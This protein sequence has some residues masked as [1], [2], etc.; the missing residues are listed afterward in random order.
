MQHVPLAY[1]VRSGFAE[2]THYGC[3][4]VLDSTRNPIVQAGDIKAPVFLR[5]AAKPLQ[6]VAMME[7][8]LSLREPHLVAL[9][10]GSH[11]GEAMHIDGVKEILTKAQLDESS[12]EN[13]V[14][15]PLSADERFKW[16]QTGRKPSHLAQNC[17]GQHAA[18][19]LCCVQVGWNIA[20]YWDY[21]HPLQKVTVEIV[22]E[23]AGEKIAAVGIDGCGLPTFGVSLH[24]LACAFSRLAMSNGPGAEYRVATAIRTC[25][26]WM[27]GPTRKVTRL[28]QG[29]KGLIAKEGA[30]GV[31]AASLPNGVSLAVKISDGNVRALWPVVAALFRE[32]EVD[33]PILEE[34]SIVPIIG[35]G[36]QVGQIQVPRLR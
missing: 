8:G 19:L 10:T 2:G 7:A 14:D 1:V 36:H 9:A 3:A 21:K 25:P 26:E 13:T 11:S 33:A 34:L 5:S 28:V 6:V 16:E 23:L 12:L 17:S 31:F 24:G 32:V 20:S 27:A 35:H 30:E 29:V 22:E 15:Y 18:M 4:V